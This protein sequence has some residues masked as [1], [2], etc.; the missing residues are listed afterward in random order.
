MNEFKYLKIARLLLYRPILYILGG[1]W[2]ILLFFSSLENKGSS[3][4]NGY[5]WIFVFLMWTAGFWGSAAIINLIAFKTSVKSM[6]RGFELYGV[7]RVPVKNWNTMITLSLMNFIFFSLFLI[8][9]FD[10]PN[11]PLLWLNTIGIYIVFIG[12]NVF[13]FALLIHTKKGNKTNP[14]PEV[15]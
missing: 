10:I 5:G 9:C 15:F 3:S 8:P 11:A 2:Q 13:Y 6:K 12:V 14:I 1:I 4:D 7:S